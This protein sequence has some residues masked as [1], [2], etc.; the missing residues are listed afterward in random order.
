MGWDDLELSQHSRRLFAFVPWHI[1][2]SSSIGQDLIM[3]AYFVDRLRHSDSNV[4]QKREP[5]CVPL[6]FRKRICNK[7]C[8]TRAISLATDK[9]T[10]F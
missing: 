3:S 9:A 1:S 8:A 4:H 5:A 7:K 10:L 6:I 2:I